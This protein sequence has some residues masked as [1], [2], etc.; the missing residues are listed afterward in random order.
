MRASGGSLTADEPQEFN[1][2]WEKHGYFQSQFCHCLAVRLWAK[3]FALSLVK[4][5]YGQ[6]WAL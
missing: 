5:G 6:D 1:V 3:H 4:E 2:S